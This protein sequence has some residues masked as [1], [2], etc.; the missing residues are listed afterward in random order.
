MDLFFRYKSGR[1]SSDSEE[2]LSSG[3]EEDLTTM[4]KNSK[5][6]TLVARIIGH[7]ESLKRK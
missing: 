1:N 5:L 2:E 7:L 3:G 4:F 6:Q